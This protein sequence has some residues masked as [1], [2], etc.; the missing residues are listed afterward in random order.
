MMDAWDEFRISKQD[1]PCSM[2]VCIDKNLKQ[3]TCVF[4]P[5]WPPFRNA[6]RYS[7]TADTPNSVVTTETRRRFR[8]DS[9]VPE[10]CLYCTLV[11]RKILTGKKGVS[12]TSKCSEKLAL[13]STYKTLIVERWSSGPYVVYLLSGFWWACMNKNFMGKYISRPIT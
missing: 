1:W 3:L 13:D 2:Y 7:N 11:S 8:R 6:L 10:V 4:S 9:V 5:C 12:G